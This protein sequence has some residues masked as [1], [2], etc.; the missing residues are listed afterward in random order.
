MP[1]DRAEAAGISVVPNVELVGL[2]DQRKI[3]ARR[4]VSTCKTKQIANPGE[5]RWPTWSVSCPMTIAPVTLNEANATDT[6]TGA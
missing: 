4:V 2:N 5:A 6:T 3:M 1:S